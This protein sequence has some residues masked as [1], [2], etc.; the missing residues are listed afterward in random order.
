MLNVQEKEVMYI[1][2][3]FDWLITATVIDTGATSTRVPMPIFSDSLSLNGEKE[4]GQV[5]LRYSLN[6]KLEFIRDDFDWIES[7]PI[8]TEFIIN[9]T[10]HSSKGDKQFEYKFYKTD[11]EF[12]KDAKTATVSVRMDDEYSEIMNNYENEY[13]VVDLNPA[14]TRFSYTIRPIWQYYSVTSGTAP[15]KV[16]NVSGGIYWEEDVLI[17]ETNSN[18]LQNTYF[19]GTPQTVGSSQ[20]YARQLMNTQ[21]S[22]GNIRPINDITA[23]NPYYKYITPLLGGGGT[24]VSSTTTQSQPTEWGLAQNGQYF[25]APINGFYLFVPIIREQWATSSYWARF[26]NGNDLAPTGAEGVPNQIRTSYQIGDLIKSFLAIIAPNIQHE[27]TTEYSQFLYGANPIMDNKYNWRWIMCPRSNITKR[28]YDNPAAKALLTFSQLMSIL[29]GLYQLYWYIEDGKLKIEHLV[30]FKNG[31]SYTDANN[32]QID[33]TSLYD[34][35]NKQ[36]WA[37]GIDQYTYDVNDLPQRY[38]FK[39]AEEV[40][41]PFTAYPINILSKYVNESRKE[42]ISLPRVTADVDYLVALPTAFNLQDWAIIV[43]DFAFSAYTS[44]L[45][46]VTL[47]DGRIVYIGNWRASFLY[48]IPTFYVYDLPSK[49]V[50]MNG[51]E[52][53]ESQ[54]KGYKRFVRQ[55]ALIPNAIDVHDFQKIRTNIGDGVIDKISINLITEIGQVELLHDPQI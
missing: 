9:A 18:V 40:T 28:D 5:F 31:L 41:T 14:I 24:I 11:C 1:D 42:E 22:V 36:P 21:G 20:V 55:Q 32:I 50:E 48:T 44:R 4:S 16:T 45:E 54:I 27:Q 53:A 3:N 35:R 2:K 26:T 43:T 17:N 34:P 46:E 8:E 25:V 19:F 15:N 49:H 33:L 30:Y 12:D 51:Y 39:Y 37:D 52:I 6:G 13:N 47:N 7:Q 29:S 10:W 38:E 23:Y